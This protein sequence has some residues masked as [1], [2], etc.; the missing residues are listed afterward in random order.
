MTEGNRLRGI[1]RVSRRRSFGQTIKRLAETA[2]RE[3][4]EEIEKAVDE[5]FDGLVVHPGDEIGWLVEMI[6]P[7]DNKSPSPRW[8]HPAHGW[9]WDANKALRF[10]RQIDA[11]DYIKSQACL[12][13]KTTEH[14][15]I[16]TQAE[17]TND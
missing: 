3:S 7:D 5:A 16:A 1:G 11:A 17:V 14:M 8:W 15:W 12:H 9:V 4:L 10:A 6:E 13:G 2:I